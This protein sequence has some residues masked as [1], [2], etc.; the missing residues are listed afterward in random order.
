MISYISFLGSSLNVPGL[1]CNQPSLKQNLNFFYF[2]NL[3]N[4]TIFPRTRTHK[5]RDFLMAEAKDIF[6]NKKYFKATQFPPNE[7]ISKNFDPEVNNSTPITKLLIKSAEIP[8]LIMNLNRANCEN[9]T[10]IKNLLKTS[11]MSECSS[12]TS[13]LDSPNGT[14]FVNHP[15]FLNPLSDKIIPHRGKN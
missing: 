3:H 9:P 15:D 10:P 12:K 14:A 7:G 5:K 13:V 6:F 4:M 8:K 11:P 1:F 2:K